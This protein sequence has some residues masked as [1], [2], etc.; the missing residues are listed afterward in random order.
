[1]TWYDASGTQLA[2]I[3]P[4]QD[5]TIGTIGTVGS[6]IWTTSFGNGVDQGGN[7][8][9]IDIG[10]KTLIDGCARWNTSQTW[11][12]GWTNPIIDLTNTFNGNLT[13]YGGISK[14][15][16]GDNYSSRV[17][18][19]PTLSGRLRV[20]GSNQSAEGTAR[21]G[22]QISLSD[23]QIYDVSSVHST[24]PIGEKW[25]DF[26]DV[27]DI[28]WIELSIEDSANSWTAL[29]GVE[30]DGEILV[31]GGSFGA[32]GFYLPF[33]PDEGIETDASGQDNHFTDENFAVGN[34]DEVWSKNT[35]I[36]SG[37]N[38]NNIFN[39][40][41][42]D[43]SNF[44]FGPMPKGTPSEYVINLPKAVSGKI[45]IYA[46][47]GSDATIGGEQ[48][49]LSNGTVLDL[50]NVGLSSKKWHDLGDQ[51]NI[52]SITLKTTSSNVQSGVDFGGILVDNVPLI[53]A[54]IQD[55]VKDTP[56]R[57][58]AVWGGTNGE[59]GNLRINNLTTGTTGAFTV[60]FGDRS[61]VYFETIKDNATALACVGVK[62]AGQASATHL[63]GDGV[64]GTD[65]QLV[66][67][68]TLTFGQ[69]D[70]VG[71][72]VDVDNNTYTVFVNGVE[73]GTYSSK[74]G[75]P[76]FSLA[77]PMANG[78]DGNIQTSNF[79]QQPFAASNVTHDWDAGTVEIDGETYGTLY[80]PLGSTTATLTI[81]DAGTLGSIEGTPTMTAKFGG[82]TGTY[83]SH[84]DTELVL[85]N[86]SGAWSVA[87]ETAISDTEHTIAAIDP[88][89]FVMT[90][91][92]FSAT[93]LEATH[94]SSTWQVTE[95]ADT[96]YAN[97]VIDVTSESALTTYNAGG[98][99]G[100]TIYRA[101][102]KHTSTN[103]V[104]SDWS[105]TISQNVFKTEPT[106]LEIP[107]ADMHGLRFDDVRQTKMYRVADAA[108]ETYTFSTWFKWTKKG[109]HSF[110]FSKGNNNDGL[111]IGANGEVGAYDSNGLTD[112]DLS[113]TENTWSHIVLKVN[114]KVVELYVN[115]VKATISKTFSTV[116]PAGEPINLG[117]FTTN[118]ANITNGYMSDVYF[119][120]G[121][122]LEPEV[123]GALFPEDPSEPNRR[124]GPLDSSDVKANIAGGVKSPS[125]TCP[126][127]SEKWSDISWSTTG[128][129]TGFAIENGFDGDI[130]TKAAV[131]GSTS[132]VLTLDF[133]DLFPASDGP[134]TLK[135][136]VWDTR[137]AGV[138]GGTT[139]DYVPTST[140]TVN[141]VDL[142]SV[143]S[144]DTIEI[145]DNGLGNAIFTAIEVNGRVL[146]DGP[147]DDSQVWSEGVNVQNLRSG[148]DKKWLF[149]GRLDWGIDANF[150]S[151]LEIDLSALS[152]SGNIK[153]HI[154]Y[155]GSATTL[156]I[157]G[158]GG[159]GGSDYTVTSNGWQNLGNISLNTLS[160][161]NISQGNTMTIHAI[162][163][164]G[165]IL[166]DGCA[167]WN[168]SQTWSDATVT[169]SINAT[170]PLTNA[171]DG[172]TSSFSR[173]TG[174]EEALVTLK[175][176]FTSVTKLRFFVDNGSSDTTLANNCFKVNGTDYS[177]LVTTT[178]GWKTIPEA[179]FDNFSMKSNGTTSVARVYAIEVNG[180]ILVDQGSFG[181][182]GFFLP[183]DP[184]ATGQVWSTDVS[185]SGSYLSNDYG[186][187]KMFN[188]VLN[189][190]TVPS[191]GSTVTWQIPQINAVQGSVK[192]WMR[193]RGST[194]VFLVNGTDYRTTLTSTLADDTEGWVTIPETSLYSISFARINDGDYGDVGAVE[195][196]GKLLVDHSAIG[197]DAS[198]Q[199]NHFQ[200]E[201]FIA[202]GSSITAINLS[203]TGTGALDPDNGFNGT[204]RSVV[205]SNPTSPSYFSLSSS[206][207]D[208]RLEL[209]PDAP[210]TLKKI[211]GVSSG[212][213]DTQVTFG[214]QTINYGG[215]GAIWQI[216]LL[217]AIEWSQANPI[218]I[219]NTN[220]SQGIWVGCLEADGVLLVDKE[221]FSN[222][223]TVKDTPMR[224]YAVLES[225]TNGNL[226][227]STQGFVKATIPCSDDIYW[228]LSTGG[229]T[230]STIESLTGVADYEVNIN[231][232]VNTNSW[233]AVGL[234]KTN[235]EIC[236][237]GRATS[238]VTTAIPFLN[239]GVDNVTGSI[240]SALYKPSTSKI[241]FAVNGRW[242]NSDLSED[243]NGY[244][245]GFEAPVGWRPFIDSKNLNSRNAVVNFGQQPFA[246]SNVTYDIDAGTV[247]IDGETY[248]TLYQTWDQYATY[249]LFFYNENTDEIIQKFTLQRRYGLTGA[250][251]SAGIYELAVQPNFAVA[252][253]I[254]EDETYV[255]IENPEPRIAAA[256]AQAEAEIAVVKAQAA[257]EVAAAE[258]ETRKYQRML[259]RAACGWVLAKAYTA[260]DII[261][262]NGHVFRAL[263]DNVATADNDPGDLD[264]TWEFL[265]LEEDAAPLA[266]DGYFP[267]YETE[268]VSDAAG[269][270]S[271]HTHTI[272]GVTYYMP[273][274]GVT[275]YH[276]NYTGFDY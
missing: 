104:D 274:G 229:S 177:S 114:A 134:Y 197:T 272:A 49:I 89:D 259:I 222:Y 208:N 53:D 251:P 80:Q 56:M 29:Y 81:A 226:E 106:L 256:E 17:E 69:G 198:G 125:D 1:M 144:I 153:L 206:G 71:C 68:T 30:L 174:T 200:D 23:G 32:N 95:V 164:D 149:D 108:I 40:F 273:D 3:S 249:G 117:Y 215:N 33:D 102:V 240:V 193:R 190:R 257:T 20:N 224:N 204:P 243:I 129:N 178:A 115:G 82:A 260:G 88:N 5:A 173:P 133:D 236:I 141:L 168:T 127:Y 225:G 6:F 72:A 39:A 46:S 245:D 41:N 209:Y 64:L 50:T 99:E 78:A 97:P 116:G 12:D 234:V 70:V 160:L 205:V 242:I 230:G 216:D 58:A 65:A 54:N 142:G 27:T 19:N 213:T 155:D 276:G 211:D 109:S 132:G 96:T 128:S 176:G 188:G 87:S 101:R 170:Y 45:E 172:S 189:E 67:G 237:N 9:R 139:V 252:A 201:N 59:N 165:K 248:G 233:V 92:E 266:I 85:S 24:T 217:S 214:G 263:E 218:V 162:E 250:K 265:G 219:T 167:K 196:N 26:G 254:K 159:A 124:W 202:E 183:F 199:G 2:V 175:Q 98:L 86:T 220:P 15:T 210:R 118:A 11:S 258:A 83:A 131:T 90:S 195:V 275:I 232:T 4:Q 119:V 262:Y 105:D 38:W 151:N 18:F 221:K 203:Y 269:N 122:A 158:G 76:D 147:A 253:Y 63:R 156:G 261:I 137:K 84:T 138:N 130:S 31:D 91:S 42:G 255:P 51:S 161:P 145:D 192:L 13:D 112:S 223:D 34:T 166:I 239:N 126:N 111:R 100:D 79:G 187:E 61:K 22:C 25:Y 268:A 169:G 185:V 270:G 123:F 244:G 212:G 60:N 184:A 35:T 75:I 52:T 150:G 207:S 157:N 181:T 44:A 7:I 143:A 179:S 180:E 94:G 57:N 135:V 113:V 77:S 163:L 66:S 8:S 182:N 148:Y 136:Y 140:A 74:G 62:L 43:T 93:P 267:L 110:I 10:N 152:L 73:G 103:N 154:N 36:V 120:D 228:E 48:I 121:Q 227:T 186:P 238:G 16:H 107:D 246:A 146:I 47:S 171:F 37:N 14:T 247:E 241:H 191:V 21:L 235:N 271:S 231:W 55:T 264:G 194:S 28:E